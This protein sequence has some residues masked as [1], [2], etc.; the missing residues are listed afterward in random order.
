MALIFRIVERTI[1]VHAKVVLEVAMIAIARKV[2]TLE[3]KEMA[4]LTL[5]GIGAIIVA[6]AV[7][8]YFVKRTATSH[9]RKAPTEVES[10]DSD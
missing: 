8:L 1:V 3:V 6:L 7:A 2:I 9:A 4:S 10:G 5:V